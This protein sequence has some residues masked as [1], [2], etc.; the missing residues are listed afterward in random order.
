M[1]LSGATGSSDMCISGNWTG[2]AAVKIAPGDACYDAV[3]AAACGITKSH[4][5]ATAVTG[6][7]STE[8]GEL[9]T[10]PN[11]GFAAPTISN[12]AVVP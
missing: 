12:G 6:L 1:P 5:A 3:I 9:V 10:A 4:P 2:P 7:T 11:A 8:Q